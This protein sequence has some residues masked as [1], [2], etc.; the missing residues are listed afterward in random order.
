MAFYRISIQTNYFINGGDNTA[1][2][3]APFTIDANTF[4]KS[5]GLAYGARACEYV[6][7]AASGFA[8]AVYCLADTSDANTA[9]CTLHGEKS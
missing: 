2:P 9:Y 7:T 6:V 8:P 1:P 3:T 4:S 5:N